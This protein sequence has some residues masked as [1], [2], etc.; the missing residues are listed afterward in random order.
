MIFGSH[1]KK[2]NII[3]KQIRIYYI[4]IYINLRQMANE[5][6]EKKRIVCKK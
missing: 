3:N 4:Y 5:K 2:L 6:K 1:N